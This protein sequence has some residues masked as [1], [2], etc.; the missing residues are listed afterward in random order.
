MLSMRHFT[1]PWKILFQLEFNGSNTYQKK[2]WWSHVYHC[3]AC[4]FLDYFRERRPETALQFFKL[5]R[6]SPIFTSERLC[7]SKML[8]LYPITVI[9]LLPINLIS[10]NIFFQLFL[11][12]NTYL[13][14]LLLPLSQHYEMCCSIENKSVFMRCA[15]HC[16]LS[17]FTF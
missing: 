1:I 6:L 12:I 15:N 9:D 10:C 17:S 14:S 5:C 16:I 8:F 13:C 3:V 4:C 11:F 7:L 2:L